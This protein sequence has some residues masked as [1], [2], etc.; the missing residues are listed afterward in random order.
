[1]CPGEI[2]LAHR[3]L[4]RAIANK[5]TFDPLAG[6]HNP[7]NPDEVSARAAESEETLED[8]VG[9][10]GGEKRTEYGG[11]GN[12]ER[13][14]CPPN[15]KALVGRLLARG[16]LAHALDANGGSGEPILDQ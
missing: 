3:A 12:A 15:M 6:V 9:E 1:V 14:P 16:T 10:I 8:L 13:A 4:E 11:A 7:A 5:P 2:L